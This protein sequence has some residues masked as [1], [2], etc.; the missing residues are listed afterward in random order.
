MAIGFDFGTANCSVAR[1]L[2]DRVEAI[3]LMDGDYYIP[4]A[5]CAPKR[6]G[7]HGRP[8]S[9]PGRR[10]LRHRGATPRERPVSGLHL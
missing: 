3:P 8:T 4:S 1:L 2:D 6:E 10:A 5:L 7:A 9:S